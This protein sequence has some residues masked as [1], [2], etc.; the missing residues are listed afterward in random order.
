MILISIPSSDKYEEAR[1]HWGGGVR[2]NKSAQKMRKRA[3]A[4]GQTLTAANA[5]KL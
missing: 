5:A 3:K 2:G 4:L 1:R